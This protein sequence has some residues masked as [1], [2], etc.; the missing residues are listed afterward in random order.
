VV[1]DGY[2][3]MSI[4]RQTVS[5]LRGLLE[6]LGAFSDVRF[7]VLDHATGDP[8][9]PG[10]RRW[11]ADSPLRSP[12]ELVD[13]SGRRA[14]MTV[15]DCL[16]P[17]WQSGAAQ[18]LL[19]EW[20]RRGPVAILQPLPQRLWSYSHARP[21]PVR[22][23]A[24]RAGV[25]NAQLTLS[26]PARRASQPA[27]NAV[28][29][30]V[31]ELDADWLASWSR[32]ISA[33]G[34]TGVDAMVVFGD[35][36]DPVSAAS[37][38]TEPALHNPRNRV[39]RF[40]A[41]ASPEAFQLA[42][43]LAAAPISLPV[44][45]LVQMAMQKMSKQSHVAEVFLGGL[46]YRIGPGD[47]ADPDAVQYDFR[48]GVREELLRRLRR[49]DAVRVLKEVS[50]LVDARFG[51]ARDF[52]ALLAGADVTGDYVISP[53]SR[54]FAEV[55]VRVLRLLGG[56][57]ALAADRLTAALPGARVRVGQEA[58][59]AAEVPARMKSASRGTDSAEPRDDPFTE[60]LAKISLPAGR[61]RERPLVCPYCYH[62]FS[63][64]NIRFRCSG[65]PGAGYA[66][67]TREVDPA[68]RKL[69][70]EE[71]LP[72]LFPAD[73][74]RDEAVCPACHGPTHIRVCPSCHSRLPANFSTVQGRLIALVG[75]RQAG[76]TA[77]MTVLI[78]E[79]RHRA[80]ERLNSSTIGADE[81]SRE[82]YVDDYESPLY[83]QSLLPT[84]TTVA[85]DY[86]TPLVFRFTMTQRTRIRE[87]QKELLL[88]FT[89]G[90]GEDLTREDKVE[91]VARYLSAA[92]GIMVV[93]DPL[94]LGRVRERLRRTAE[95][96]PLLRSDER[97]VASFDRITR[98][99][100]AGSGT[101]TI[102]K[103]VALVLTKL[104]ML[105]PLL[106]P[107]SPLRATAPDAPYFD[108]LDSA[109]VQQQVSDTLN[110]WNAIGLHE[111]A[112]ENY[113]RYRFFPVSA[114]GAPPTATNRV[115]PQGITPYRVTDPFMWLLSEF[116][117]I[118]SRTNH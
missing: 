118:R 67:C 88:S 40:R 70:Q 59:R 110:E 94:Q 109:A 53:E 52:P 66:A 100:L 11:Q 51:Q 95:L 16:G 37:D 97:P 117:F 50:T 29:I 12:H 24:A 43:Y 96:P 77:F 18:Q 2:D 17:M 75:P 30:P 80:G 64:R 56:Q 69:G 15:S 92:D 42:V 27:T 39:G 79:L 113:T 14:I 81:K 38:A 57:Y 3:S 8:S 76:K 4:W 32:L 20:G 25:P 46:L 13:P 115:P 65:Q 63:E 33:S 87:Q 107:D 28:P 116:S 102:D 10:V 111:L 47:D 68:L 91:R 35:S 106:Q 22:L 90:A 74:R 21:L 26:P 60:A 9:R 49:H 99:L 71:P 41:T 112:R 48:P 108:A 98:L 93:V 83:K 7:W 86:I 73:G 23:R 5:E 1:V 45:R 103:P 6:R 44:I 105:R 84:P 61:S 31:L 85:D 19:A 89:D 114:L 54:L 78:H 62:A 101:N 72:P 34:T 82:R 58:S 55:A 104:D 36:T